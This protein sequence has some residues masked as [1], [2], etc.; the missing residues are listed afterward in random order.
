VHIVSAQLGHS[1]PSVTLNVYAH[2]LPTSD[3]Q[4]ARTMAAVLA[5]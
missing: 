5:G 1:T 3:E 4:A 2:M